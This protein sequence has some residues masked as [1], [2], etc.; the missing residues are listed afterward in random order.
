MQDRE[1]AGRREGHSERP[2]GRLKPPGCSAVNWESDPPTAGR[3]TAAS[4]SREAVLHLRVSR[5]AGRWAQSQGRSFQED[6]PPTFPAR[7]PGTLGDMGLSTHDAQTASRLEKA[8][9]RPPVMQQR[10]PRGLS[11]RVW[12]RV[13]PPLLPLSPAF[14]RPRAHL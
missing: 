2:V 5:W 8:A 3:Q 12:W 9:A 14:F 1:V 13:L 10:Q 7:E 11:Q 4:G 6:S